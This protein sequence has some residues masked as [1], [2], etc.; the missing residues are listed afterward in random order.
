MNTSVAFLVPAQAA[1]DLLRMGRLGRSNYSTASWWN[2]SRHNGFAH[3]G[4]RQMANGT[5]PT[6]GDVL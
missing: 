3:V 6:H 5:E 2:F 4:A 1:Q